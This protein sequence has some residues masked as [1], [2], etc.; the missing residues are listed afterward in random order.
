VF[1]SLGSGLLVGSATLPPAQVDLTAEGLVDWTHWG[2]TT[3]NSYNH[4]GGASIRISNADRIG[5]GQTKRYTDNFSGYSW[6]NGVP[7]LAAAATTTGIY[8]EGLAEGFEIT[9]PADRTRRRLKV[10]VGLFASQARF[11]AALSDNS[12]ATY[13]NTSLLSVYGNNY[14]VYTIDYQAASANQ[15]LV[16]KHTAVENF[17]VLYGNVTLQAA[18]LVDLPPFRLANTV[19]EDDSLHFSVATLPYKSYQAQFAEQMPATN[20]QTF[21]TFPGTGLEVWVTNSPLTS[22]QRFYRV[23]EY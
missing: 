1:V 21:A 2:L 15:Q 17:D 9:A 7:T 19:H 23:V 11:E 5:S 10:Y 13:V 20:W 12:A 16:V 8:A 14:R 4:R 3:G 18:T 22:T 6:T